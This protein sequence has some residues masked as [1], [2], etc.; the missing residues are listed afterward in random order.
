VWV[1]VLLDALSYASLVFLVAAGLTL[2][3]GVM[4][5]LNVAHASFYALGAYVAVTMRLWMI[6]HGF[7]PVLTFLT[8]VASGILVGI[9]LGVFT[10]RVL[11][12]RVY[13]HPDVLQLLLTFGLFMILE[14][15]Q[16]LVWGVRPYYEDTPVQL[17]GYVDV[18]GVFYSVYQLVALPLVAVAVILGLRWFLER[19]L[20]GRTVVA[21]TADWEMA[22]A[23]GVDARRVY[24]LTFV[25]GA[26]LAALGGG[27]AS[28]FISMF[29]GIAVEMIV[30]SFA[31]AITA[32]L[33]NITGAALTAVLIGLGRSAAVYV[34][35]E[36]DMAMPYLIMM[37]V[38]LFRPYGLFRAPEARKA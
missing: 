31:V 20:L 7:P 33:G 2:I 37:V 23:I 27:L 8:V 36:L 18:G 10:E 22:T 30:L 17:L 13:G 26:S 1:F 12:R 35:P 24:L 5:I 14:D 4:R 38:L 11:L 16:R 21:V 32:G 15:V 29:P 28:P 9:T 6:A 34:W 3:F 25:I 19:T